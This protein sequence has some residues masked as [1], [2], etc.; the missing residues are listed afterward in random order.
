MVR[1]TIYFSIRYCML[2]NIMVASKTRMSVTGKFLFSSS[3][4][5]LKDWSTLF[6]K[7]WTFYQ[8][9]IKIQ[10]C[11]LMGFSRTNKNNRA[12]GLQY[13]LLPITSLLLEKLKANYNNRYI[14]CKIGN[15][16]LVHVFQWTVS[17][18]SKDEP[19]Q[20]KSFAST[21][22]F[23][24]TC[25][26]FLYS[27]KTKSQNHRITEWPGLEGTSRIMNLQPP[28]QAGPSISPFTRPGCPGPHPTWPW[29]PPGTGHLQPLWA[30]RSS[31]S[32]LSW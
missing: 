11:C 10:S 17:F 26:R 1:V 12:L 32:P 28:C 9:L 16:W 15:R 21:L 25:Q 18:N 8:I 27:D 19:F 5:T 30:A 6:H 31:T 7:L 4:K 23:K 24:K 14:L 13:S 3:P 22:Q 29:T 2:M 20:M